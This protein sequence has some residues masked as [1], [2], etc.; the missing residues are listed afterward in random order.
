[1]SPASVY[2]EPE[3]STL[4]KGTLKES[5]WAALIICDWLEEFKEAVE[6]RTL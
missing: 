1:M 3:L 2:T 4:L 6:L 5:G